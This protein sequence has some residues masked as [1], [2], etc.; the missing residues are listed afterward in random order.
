M[1]NV[2]T[3][4]NLMAVQW[5][6]GWETILDDSRR[7][8]RF[9]MKSRLGK[10]RKFS[11][12]HLMRPPRRPVRAAVPCLVSSILEKSTIEALPFVSNK[13]PLRIQHHGA[14]H[15]PITG[16]AQYLTCAM[17]FTFCQLFV[18]WI[19]RRKEEQKRLWKDLGSGIVTQDWSRTWIH[20]VESER[21]HR[22]TPTKLVLFSHNITPW[23]AV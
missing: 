19:S 12:M 22:R 8:G 1:L 16:A 3:S 23:S 18:S 15:E 4:W 5:A 14:V 21:Q 2:H 17:Q 13:R 20:R 11:R 9:R 6:F 7:P 10:A